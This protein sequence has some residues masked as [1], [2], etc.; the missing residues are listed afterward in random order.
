MNTSGFNETILPE[1]SGMGPVYDDENIVFYYK[2]MASMYFYKDGEKK[3]NWNA[4]L[5]NDVEGYEE[6][7]YSKENPKWEIEKKRKNTSMFPESS[8]VK[9]T[10]RKN[11]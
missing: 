3:G 8:K 7:K 10:L 9:N 2:D 5:V 6:Y 11:I 4:T 1:N